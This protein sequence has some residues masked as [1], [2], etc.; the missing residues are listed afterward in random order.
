M[1]TTHAPRT[2]YTFNVTVTLREDDVLDALTRAQES[3]DE[4]DY[5]IP[6]PTEEDM[7]AAISDLLERS[8][9]LGTFEAGDNLDAFQIEDVT[10]DPED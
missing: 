1:A 8:I 4:D 6:A 3:N 2:E 9:V 10:L 7:R 5:P